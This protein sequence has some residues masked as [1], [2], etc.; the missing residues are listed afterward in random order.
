MRLLVISESTVARVASSLAPA[1]ANSADPAREME[2][3][4]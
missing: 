3:A 4:E 2:F 1:A